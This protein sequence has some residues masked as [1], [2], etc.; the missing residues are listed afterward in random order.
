MKI[1]YLDVEECH[2]WQQL[3]MEGTSVMT[4]KKFM[5]IHAPHQLHVCL[6]IEYVAIALNTYGTDSSHAARR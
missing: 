5:D 2:L 3:K 6:Q 4:E 1:G